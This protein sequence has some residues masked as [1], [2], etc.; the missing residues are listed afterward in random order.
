MKKT[1]IKRSL[2]IKK[3]EFTEETKEFEIRIVLNKK[4]GGGKNDI[5]R[6]FKRSECPR[7]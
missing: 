1:R 6:I 7:K 3:Y 2:H 4:L 5:K